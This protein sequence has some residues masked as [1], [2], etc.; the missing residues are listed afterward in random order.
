M[1]CS[2]CGEKIKE[3][4]RFCAKCGTPVNA[5]PVPNTPPTAGDF[6]G[7]TP[8]QTRANTAQGIANQPYA[9]VQANRQNPSQ[10]A[11]LQNKK[12]IKRNI[13]IAA[14]GAVL[15]AVLIIGI[16]A[17]APGLPIEKKMEKEAQIWRQN[18]SID[19]LLESGKAAYEKKDYDFAI[20]D[21]TQAI[22]LDPNNAEAYNRRAFAYSG[23]GNEDRAIADYT[24]VIQLAP[25]KVAGIYVNRGFS[26][27]DKG[28]YNRA[29]MDFEAALQF[30]ENNLEAIQNDKSL[31]PDDRRRRETMVSVVED[32]LKEAKQKLGTTSGSSSTTTQQSQRSTT[33]Q[34]P[35]TSG[36]TE[37]LTYY[38]DGDKKTATVEYLGLQQLRYSYDAGRNIICDSSSQKPGEKWTE[39]VQTDYIKNP[40]ANAIDAMLF[41]EINFYSAMEWSEDGEKFIWIYQKN[42]PDAITDDFQFIKESGNYFYTLAKAYKKR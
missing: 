34:Q 32:K 5:S 16:S 13:L 24:Q 31:S 8:E 29:V 26:Y 40:N 41:L 3:E 38:V 2:K 22:R 23:K 7:V 37:T 4:T 33:P 20:A 17:N 15:I 36:N 27:M 11:G 6:G 14:A 9:D 21:F 35:S 42:N 19:D 12:N 18:A 39:W 1:F 25:P 28:D 10:T 30:P